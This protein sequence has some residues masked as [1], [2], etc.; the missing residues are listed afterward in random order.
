[1]L[2]ALVLNF[3]LLIAGTFAVS[4]T[5]GRPELREPWWRAGL[6]LL[7]SVLVAFLILANSVQLAPGL[8]FDFRSVPVALAAR[9][10]GVLAGLLVALPIAA[11][12]LALGGPAAWAGVL[13]L[14]LVAVLGGWSTGLFRPTPRMD[15]LLR[16]RWWL[17]FALYG[18]ANLTTFLAFFLAGRPLK[19]AVPAYLMF[20]SLS[21]VGM[22]AG[23]LVIQTRLQ[24]L[25]RAEELERLAYVDPLTGSLNRRRF[26]DDLLAAPQPAYLLMLDLDHF[27]RV[28]DTYG[29][30]VGDQVLVQLAQVLREAA[31]PTDGVYRLGGEEFAV[32]L[33]P[34]EEGQVER[35]AE[36]LREE[37]ARQVAERAGLMTETITVSGGLVRI[38]GEKRTL[39]RAADER[40]YRAKTLGRNAVVA[41]L[42]AVPDS[43]EAEKSPLALDKTLSGP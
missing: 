24:A 20:A 34:C 19:E 7:M 12:R 9:R 17:P 1:M 3:A 6:R 11:Y 40:L 14:V 30:G 23:H 41:E 26:D 37:V 10:S 4:L 42:P 32:I 27:K 15:D 22:L 39:L 5:Y 38:R 29:H 43:A 25:A 35:V 31:R 16:R 2:N 8:L 28:N 33:A 13:N 18:A 21:A 36:R